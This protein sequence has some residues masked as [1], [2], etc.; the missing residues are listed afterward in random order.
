MLNIVALLG[1]TAF[2]SA[3]QSLP[4]LYLTNAVVLTNGY[5]Q[6]EVRTPDTNQPYVLLRSWAKDFCYGLPRWEVEERFQLDSPTNRYLITLPVQMSGFG[7]IFWRVAP[8]G[9]PMYWLSY[10]IS[11]YGTLSNGLGVVSWPKQPDGWEA[12]LTVQ[13]VTNSPAA[14]EVFFTGPPGSGITNK[15][16]DSDS[17]NGYKHYYYVTGPSAVPPTGNWHVQYGTNT[18]TFQMADPKVSSRYLVMVPKL[19]VSNDILTS[20]SWTYHDPTTGVELAELPDYIAG[21]RSVTVSDTNYSQI[22]DSP[23]NDRWRT[24]YVFGDNTSDQAPKWSDVGSLN[25][26]FQDNL[27]NIYSFYYQK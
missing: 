14:S 22:Y 8:L 26:G 13:N 6:F 2:S 1:A 27:G 20:I 17:G 18:L 25:I 15:P 10:S 5:G 16:P 24:T 19:V 9:Q 12:Q 4:G 23:P 11:S 21:S 3:G 7:S